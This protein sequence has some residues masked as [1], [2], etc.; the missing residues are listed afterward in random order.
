MYRGSGLTEL[1]RGPLDRCG[2]F[3]R[4]NERY[5]SQRRDEEQRQDLRYQA[6]H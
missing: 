4:A 1:R 3:V 2:L 5:I 6:S